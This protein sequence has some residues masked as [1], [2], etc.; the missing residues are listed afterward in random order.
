MGWGIEES[1]TFLIGQAS[2]PIQ[3]KLGLILKFMPTLNAC[4]KD[5]K[6]LRLE[7]KPTQVLFQGLRLKSEKFYRPKFKNTSNDRCFY[8]INCISLCH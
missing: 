4:K 8:Y 3:V 2:K 5:G 6:E 1:Q 7:I